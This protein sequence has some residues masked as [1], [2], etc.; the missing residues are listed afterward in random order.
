MP[1][2]IYNYLNSSYDPYQ[3][4]PYQSTAYGS[5][6][7]AQEE[8]WQTAMK[9]EQPWQKAMRIKSQWQRGLNALNFGGGA[10]FYNP[11]SGIGPL[12]EPVRAPSSTT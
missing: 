3:Y 8:P 10:S 12:G 7:D 9:M 5:T 1:A 4:A 2:P 6:P 11:P